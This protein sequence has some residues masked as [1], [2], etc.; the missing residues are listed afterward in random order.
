MCNM[1]DSLREFSNLV[2]ELSALITEWKGLTPSQQA[3]QE[4]RFRNRHKEIAFRMAKLPKPP[5]KP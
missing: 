5:G 1:N 2:E 3:Q 4:E